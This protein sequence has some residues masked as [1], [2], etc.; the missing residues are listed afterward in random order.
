M[1][2]TFDILFDL[3]AGE[4]P[5]RRPCSPTSAALVGRLLL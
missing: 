1:L 3:H 2:T 5:S 4:R